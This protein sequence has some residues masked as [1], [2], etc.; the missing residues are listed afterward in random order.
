M[1]F[2]EAYGV[3][4]HGHHLAVQQQGAGGQDHL[5]LPQQQ[6][7]LGAEPDRADSELHLAQTDRHHGLVAAGDKVL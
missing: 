1:W 4:G 6:D 5:H 7:D 2:A 3:H